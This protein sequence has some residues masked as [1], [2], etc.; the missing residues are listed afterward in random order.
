MAQTNS[1][2]R[3][4]VAVVGGCQAGLSISWYLAKSGIDHVCWK[5]NVPGRLG[6]PSAGTR[7]V[8]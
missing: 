6:E 4:S 3:H 2:A 8:W 5:K 1:V 7:S